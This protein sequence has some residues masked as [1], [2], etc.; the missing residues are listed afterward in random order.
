L[1]W[2]DALPHANVVGG[3][4]FFIGAL[5][6]ASFAG[7]VLL[8]VL[9][10][11]TTMTDSLADYPR[12]FVVACATIVLAVVLWI[13]LKLLKLALWML[14]GIVLVVGLGAAAWLLIK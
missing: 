9:T 6:P 11:V 13:G 5:A 12:W 7:R 3:G 8:A 4:C 2:G 1:A 10:K 14:I